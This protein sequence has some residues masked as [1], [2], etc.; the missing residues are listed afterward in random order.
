MPC[1]HMH[2][3][4]PPQG[5]LLSSAERG[6]FYRQFIDAL[7]QIHS[8]PTSDARKEQSKVRCT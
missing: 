6:C 1:D 3:Q 5:K 7:N 4:Q 2:L 8:R